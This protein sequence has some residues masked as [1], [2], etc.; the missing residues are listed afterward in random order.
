MELS[1]VT[2]PF[3][4]DTGGFPRDPLQQ[5]NG[6]VVSVVEHLFHHDGWPWLLLV[7]HHK[8]P[9]PETAR[10]RSGPTTPPL[11]DDERALY[12]RLRAWR[13]GRAQADAVPPYTLLTNRQLAAL[14]QARPTTVTG[15]LDIPGVGPARVERFGTDVLEVLGA[16]P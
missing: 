14:A 5:I 9:L 2:M 7:V 6:T 10:P 1:L 12:E 11:S 15:L 13:N 8:P 3:D 4:P 16:E